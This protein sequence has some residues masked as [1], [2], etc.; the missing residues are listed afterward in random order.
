MVNITGVMVLLLAA[1]P[2]STNYTLKAFDFGNG[3]G[4]TTSSGYQLNVITNGQ[5][6]GST[7]SSTSYKLG[8]GVGYTINA[9]VPLAPSLTNPSNYYERLKLVLATNNNPSLTKYAIAISSDNFATTLYVQPDNTIGAAYSLANY[10]THTAWGGAGGFYILGLQPGTTYKVKVR[11]LNGDYSG[12][13]FGPTASGATVLPSVTFSVATSLTSTP[14]FNITFSNLAPGA[15]V[16]STD[17]DPVLN[18]STNALLGG[19]IYIKDSVSGLKSLVANYTLSSATADLGATSSGYG[20][21]VISA[22]Q[23]SGGPIQSASPYNLSGNNVGAIS[24]VLKEILSSN[25][26]VDGAT[27]T[28]RLKARTN[29]TI[30]SSNDYSDTLTFIASMSF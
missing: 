12:T 21:Q 6:G 19:T 2:S 17:Y 16:Y 13:A 15:A 28:I 5:A 30:P 9:N 7:S 1:L 3:G 23:V 22:S 10:Q 4:S 27:A 11:A 24:N 29:I 26:Q 20:A 14:P 18:L 25:S 8:A